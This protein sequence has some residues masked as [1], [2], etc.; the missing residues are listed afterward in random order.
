MTVTVPQVFTEKPYNC[1]LQWSSGEMPDAVWEISES[2]STPDILH[3]YCSAYVDS[4][5]HVRGMVNESISYRAVILNGDKRYGQ[6]EI[7]SP[8]WLAWVG[9]HLALS[10]HSCNSH[11]HWSWQQYRKHCL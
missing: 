7:H 5:F 1:R 3:P 10:P 4:A 6:W 11:D 2:H 8:S 9:S